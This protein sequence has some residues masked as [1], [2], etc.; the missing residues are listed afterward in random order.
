[1]K[2]RPPK[3]DTEKKMRG[4]YKPSRSTGDEVREVAIIE[5]GEPMVPLS[6][7]AYQLWIDITHMLISYNRLAHVDIFQISI[8]CQQYDVYLGTI[9]Q[10]VIDVCE[11]GTTKPSG[12]YKVQ[13]SAIDTI[14]R[15]GTYLGVSP[16]LR[17]RLRPSDDAKGKAEDPMGNFL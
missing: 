17:H 8:L 4:T 7:A 3:T 5:A 13:K 16:I 9:D 6:P 15:L 14:L 10:G 1:M 12:W 2:G 11:D